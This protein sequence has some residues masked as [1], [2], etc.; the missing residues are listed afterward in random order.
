MYP[1]RSKKIQEWQQ[2]RNNL[3]QLIWMTGLYIPF[4]EEKICVCFM[5]VSGKDSG[6]STWPSFEAVPWLVLT[7]RKSLSLIE[8]LDYRVLWEY[9]TSN[10]RCVRGKKV[11][12]AQI[13][14][15]F[16][17]IICN[18]I[19]VRHNSNGIIARHRRQVCVHNLFHNFCSLLIMPSQT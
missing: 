7:H 5:T 9:F 4:A 14:S 10:K 17:Q 16:P 8:T 13:L 11:A 3:I 2:W 6:R 1:L 18:S 15:K 12:R 19:I